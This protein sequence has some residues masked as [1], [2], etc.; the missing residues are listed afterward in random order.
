MKTRYKINE[1]T[2]SG[3]QAKVT[4][5]LQS[6][7]EN[8]EVHLN[9]AEAVIESKNKFTLE[10]LQHALSHKGPYTIQEIFV[11]PD[12]TE[13]Y[14]EIAHQAIHSSDKH[15]ET[16][17]NL[18]HLAGKYYCPMLCEGDKVYDSNVGC[19]VCGMDLVK[20]GGNPSDNEEVNH[21]KK[22]F[23]QSLII[24]IPVFIIAMFGMN[25]DSFIYNIIP[26]KM[27]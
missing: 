20:I 12:G 4:Q 8:V 5:A 19:P 14:S 17:K 26:F 10:E 18:E 24:T 16:P 2:C 6:V 25:H 13:T 9:P 7:T 15:N 27:E 22:L 23:Y 11:Q 1:M 3:C 21:L